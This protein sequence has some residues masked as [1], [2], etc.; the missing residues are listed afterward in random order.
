MCVYHHFVFKIM[1]IIIL[2]FKLCVC[3]HACMCTWLWC[4]QRPE[5]IG[6]PGRYFISSYELRDLCAGD[7]TFLQ[8]QYT[9]QCWAISPGSIFR[10]VI[11]WPSVCFLSISFSILTL[12]PNI[13]GVIPAPPM[14]YTENDSQEHSLGS[15]KVIESVD[16]FLPVFIRGCCC[17]VAHMWKSEASYR[18]RE[19]FFSIMLVLGFNSGHQAKPQVLLPEEPAH[20]P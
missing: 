13:W 4:Q 15:R 12:Y 17:A 14:C 9:L 7:Q 16:S 19:F 10:L 2:F 20:C 8:K 3:V 5:G 6:S 11:W 18:K 1:C